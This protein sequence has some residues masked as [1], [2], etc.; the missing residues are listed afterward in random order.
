MGTAKIKVKGTKNNVIN[1]VDR[2]VSIYSY[3]VELKPTKFWSWRKFRFLYKATLKKPSI[4]DEEIKDV[5]K[6]ISNR[7]SKLNNQINK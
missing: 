5:I 7:C 4:T 3:E 2:F 1:A 6:S